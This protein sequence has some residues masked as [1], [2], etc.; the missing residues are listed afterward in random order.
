VTSADA[1]WQALA[2]PATYRSNGAPAWAARPIQRVPVIT[3]ALRAQARAIIWCDEHLSAVSVVLPIRVMSEA[4]MRGNWRG[5]AGRSKAHRAAAFRGLPSICPVRAPIIVVLTRVATHCLDSDNLA[6][7]LKAVRDGVSDWLGI[8]D[9]DESRVVF[10]VQQ[11]KAQIH[12]VGIEI[13]ERR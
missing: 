9:G 2:T 6:R 11:R 7:A 8:D 3:E 13:W 1:M 5:G 10:L 4:N 12:A